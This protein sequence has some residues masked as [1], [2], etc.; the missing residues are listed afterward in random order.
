MPQPNSTT[1]FSTFCFRQSPEQPVGSPFVERSFALLAQRRNKK[2]TR[3][4]C[5]ELVLHTVAITSHTVHLWRT[6][7]FREMKITNITRSSRR[8]RLSAG[9][10]P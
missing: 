2:S 1:S 5:L 7:G 6:D 9:F 3:F 4:F 8:L 10:P